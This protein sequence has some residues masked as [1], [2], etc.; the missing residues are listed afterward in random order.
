LLPL[1]GA[2]L[3]L[4]GL[5]ALTYQVVWVR[6][7]GLSM[8]STA[9]S[10][11]TVLAAFFGGL[12]LG[13]ALAD[14]LA[15]RRAG[16][17]A[18]LILETLIGVAGLV[19]LP[20]LLRLD[21]LVAELPA[22]GSSLAVKFATTVVLLSVPT[23]CMGATFPV[24]AELLA[25]GRSDLGS[26]M[27]FLYSLNTW[28]AVAGAGLAGFVLIPRLGLDGAVMVAA[29]CNFAIVAVGFATRGR[30]TG[31]AMLGPDAA[32]RGASDE[33]V[34]DAP[35]AG[36]ALASL[37]ATGFCSIAAEVGWTKYL[38]IFTGATLY[39]F[40]TI[41][42]VFLA[43]IALGSWL[44][45]PLLGREQRT[46]ELLLWGLVVLGLSV[47]LT[48]PAL[49]LAPSVLAA[50][51]ESGFAALFAYG[52]VFAVLLPPTLLFGAL[53]PAGLE[54]YCGRSGSVRQRSGRAYALNTLAGIAGSVAAG[55][56]AIPI[57]GTDR[58]LVALALV[59][60]LVAAVAAA[61]GRV[62]RGATTRR[63]RV[64]VAAAAVAI[65][66]ISL[67]GLDY[68]PL[69]RAVTLRDPAAA[70][71]DPSVWRFE[72]LREAR[73]GVISVL[74]R[75][76][77]MGALQTNGLTESHLNF[78][79]PMAGSPTESLLG[80][81]PYL[82]HGEPRAAF[83]VGFGGGNTAFGL[84]RTAEL[85][86]IRVV[87][88]E[89]AIVDAVR[90]A[91]R[92]YVAALLD[93]RLDLRFNDARNALL[94]EDTLYDLIV[95][96]PSHPWLAGSGTLFT[97]EFFTIISSR[98]RPGGV[99]GQWVNLFNMDDV[100]LGAILK[101]FY[102]VFPY[103]FALRPTGGHDLLVFGSHWP[104]ILDPAR[105]ETRLAHRE[106]ATHL[107]RQRVSSVPD[108]LRDFAFSRTEILRAV[109][110]GPANT[111]TNLISE[112]RLARI[113]GGGGDTASVEA[114]LRSVR[115]LDVAPHLPRES[116]AKVL[117]DLAKMLTET[118]RSEDAST[119][120][121][122]RGELP[123]DPVKLR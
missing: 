94:V 51:R 32:A 120:A 64:L 77:T 72:Y 66:T 52:F 109:Q 10:V 123:P 74:T 97:R 88:L 11:S 43:G 73:A 4:S 89:P 53:F 65:V 111:D 13:S 8:G 42:V 12:A 48:R 98:L 93:P 33:A 14:R 69:V 61:V 5:A 106:L 116:A 16:I 38:A 95:S 45:R 90:T 15:R 37:V 7:L 67:P 82:L 23:I 47:A 99:F 44:V 58:L 31:G 17:D 22:M 70:G 96:Q 107:A 49:S 63:G 27:S 46:A 101:S 75:D 81:V 6:L 1:A 104:L 21:S 25:R 87:E 86:T 2:F 113:G 55:F 108:L 114:L 54:L 62:G 9:A 39:G 40:A 83:V 122:R 60:P 118:G 112:V 117:E 19:L 110:A 92:G 85:E 84:T 56:W 76:G 79:D 100:T 26:R 30:F 18:Y 50:A 34:A 78:V 20:V 35:Y 119:I 105:L 102:E 115:G 41:L 29:A 59:F 71:E 57:F 28:G 36:F 103:G 24:M 91:S 68:Q 121:R 3:L 80:L